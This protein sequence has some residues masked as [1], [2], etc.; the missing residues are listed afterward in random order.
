MT[1]T[2]VVPAC[3]TTSLASLGEQPMLKFD[4]SVLRKYFSKYF[5]N[6]ILNA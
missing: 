4:R 6:M 2:L 5:E 1:Y 3:Q